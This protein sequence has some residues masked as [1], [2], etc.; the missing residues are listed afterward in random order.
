MDL[1]LSV[2]RTER[3]S[4]N[5]Y[6]AA[7]R[8]FGSW[9]NALLAAGIT[10][11]RAMPSEQW[12]PARIMGTIRRLANR[13][14]PWTLAQIEARHGTMLSAARRTYGSWSR[15]LIAAGVDPDAFQRASVWTS[16]RVIEAILL[17]TLKNESL[18]Y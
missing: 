16:Q 14:R 6:Q 12:P 11:H 13:K 18:G 2:G 9:Q 1:P 8:I 10:P 15:S 5:L 7:T 17:R 4:A 3:A